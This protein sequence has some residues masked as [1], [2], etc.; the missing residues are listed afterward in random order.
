MA[1]SPGR[2]AALIYTLFTRGDDIV[3]PEGTSLEMVLQRPL[4]LQESQ[5]AGIMTCA[6]IRST[7]PGGQPQPLSKPAHIVCPFR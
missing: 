7:F 1:V 3:I 4:D 6:E 2:R 5:L